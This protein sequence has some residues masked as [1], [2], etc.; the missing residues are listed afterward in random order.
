M[1]IYGIG[2]DIINISRIE[3]ILKK[4]KIEFKKKNFYKKR[5]FLL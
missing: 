5:N 3:K 1:S 2:A 4:N